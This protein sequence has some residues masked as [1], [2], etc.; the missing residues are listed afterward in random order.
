MKYIFVLAFAL[1]FFGCKNKKEE[2]VEV[3]LSASEIIDKSIAVS[4]GKAFENSV[5][6]FNFRAIFYKAKRTK[7]TF[8]LKR[9]QVKDGDSV[10]DIL[11]N[12]GFERYVNDTIFEVSDKEREVYTASVNSVHYFSVLPYGLNDAAVNKKLIGEIRIKDNAY[13]KIEITFSEINGGEDYEDIFIYWINKQTFKP[14]YLA[15]SYNEDD[16]M[17]MRFRAAYN[18][19][20]INGLRFVDY[21]NYKTENK[22]IKLTDLDTA[23][24]NSELKLLSK[25]EL[26]N[27]EVDLIN[28]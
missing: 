22:T 28:N 26:K 3:Q 2:V 23:F 7:N 20:Y 25:I 10:S 19:R 16:D 5:I 24:I 13:Y 4:G 6:A 27:I 17:G 9:L 14:D 11:N 1:V 21:Y 12:K 18:E 8:E 15:Y